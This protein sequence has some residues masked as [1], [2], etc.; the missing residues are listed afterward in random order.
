MLLD[1]HLEAVCAELH[2]LAARSIEK[3]LLGKDYVE[4]THAYRNELCTR[5]RR[6]RWTLML[7]TGDFW[8]ES[9][10]LGYF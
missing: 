5:F 7:N 4:A 1:N 3:A 2:Y 6:W 8:R 10:K 9:K